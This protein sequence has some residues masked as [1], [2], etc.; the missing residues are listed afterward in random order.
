MTSSRNF[1]DL[2]E[3]GSST[4]RVALLPCPFDGTSTY[5][6]G[7]D[8]GPEAILRAG[9]QLEEFDLELRR[10]PCDLGIEVR[11]PVRFTADHPEEAV[12]RIQAAAKQALA[13][14]RFLVGLG[15]EHTVS[16][17]LTRAC[18]EV[19]GPFHI[20]Q[21]DAHADLRDEYLGSPY[22][23]ACVMRRVAEDDPKAT[24][25]SVGIRACCEEE[26]EYAERR[27]VVLHL[28]QRIAGQRQWIE[29]VVAQLP[30]PVY[31]T[32]D[33]DGLDP[34][35]LPATGTPMPGGL[36]WYE[37]LHLLRRVGE[38]KRVVACDVTELKPD[39][40]H[41]HAEFLAAQLVYKMI[42]YFVP[43]PP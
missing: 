3:S 7:A 18:R 35:I 11:P 38:E 25:I 19:L 43:T 23:H 30:D 5:A 32:V 39:P 10:R 37:T 26:L 34:S 4:P 42:G 1:L 29:E 24:V 12:A 22:N 17:G 9:P 28:A 21:I 13:A 33:L 14:S 31:V 6:K 2:P 41:H 20:L 40:I 8:R 36:G 27:G 15:G 16:V